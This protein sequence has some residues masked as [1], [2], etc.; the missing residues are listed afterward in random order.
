MYYIAII[1]I[2]CCK[3]CFFKYSNLAGKYCHY[4]SQVINIIIVLI[5]FLIVNFVIKKSEE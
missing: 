1:A 4:S 3:T 5:S 2:L